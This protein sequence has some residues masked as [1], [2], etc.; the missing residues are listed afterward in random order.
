MAFYTHIVTNKYI[1]NG[2]VY[3]FNNDIGRKKITFF[4][5]TFADTGFWTQVGVIWS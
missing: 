2:K 3:N 5:F 4:L 1:N